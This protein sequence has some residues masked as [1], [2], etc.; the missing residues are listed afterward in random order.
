MQLTHKPTAATPLLQLDALH[1]LRGGHTILRHLNLRVHAQDRI[2]LLGA[3]GSGKST[4]LHA[5]SGL[6]PIS[7]G[8]LLWQ[9]QWLQ[10]PN[11]MT[12]RER[13]LRRGFQHSHCF[14]RLSI[15]QHVQLLRAPH[16]HDL[17]QRLGLNAQDPRPSAQ[18]PYS[19]QRLLDL[20]LALSEDFSL[21]LLD[22]PTAGLDSAAC[23]R[24]VAAIAHHC[25]NTASGA[26]ILVEHNEAVLT[27]LCAQRLQLSALQ[28]RA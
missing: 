1:V 25:R 15:L 19:Q 8:R 20:L 21:L 18:L 2:A 5:I 6:C 10:N 28:L 27:A 11:C 24:A 13:G 7:D 16:S 12:L 3:N 9:G 4:L 23:Q 26:L 22:E 17:L 14:A